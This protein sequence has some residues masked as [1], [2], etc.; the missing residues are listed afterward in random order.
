MKIKDRAVVPM[1]FT[2]V[3]EERD[4]STNLQVGTTDLNERTGN[5]YEN[6]GSA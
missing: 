5:V 3:E 4:R 6:K 1:T 2:S